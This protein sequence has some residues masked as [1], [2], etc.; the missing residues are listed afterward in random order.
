MEKTDVNKLVPYK[1]NARAHSPKQVEQIARSIKAFGF[2]NP[3]LVDEG[4]VVIAGHGRLAA[5]KRLGLKE[6]PVVRLNHLSEKEKKAYILADNR[7]AEKASWDPARLA[8]EIKE[9]SVD[10][11]FDLSLT[12]FET[13]ETDLILYGQSAPDEAETWDEP[14][15]IPRLVQKG[16][17]WALGRHKLVCGDALDADTLA[18]LMGS[19]K[20]D[21][22]LTDPPYNVKIAGHVCGNGKIKHPEFAMASGE[23]KETEF[24][25]FLTRAFQNLRAFSKDG[26]LHF[27][28]IDWR[29][30]RVMLEAGESVYDEL[31]NIC[32]WAKD[33]GAMGSL[34]RS[35]HELVCVF[36]NGGAPHCNNIE[37]GKYGRCRTNVW[38]YPGVR[39]QSRLSKGEPRLHP[40]V[41]PAGLLADVL[42]D[43]S[44]PGEIALDVFGGSGSTLLAAE[45][46]GRRAR[47]AELDPHYCDVILYRYEK[48]GGK[49]VKLVRRAKYEIKNTQ[50]PAGKIPVRF[51]IPAAG[52]KKCVMR[53]RIRAASG[54]EPLSA[55]TV[56]Q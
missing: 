4:N 17:V 46:T 11:D 38:E 14:V 6:V 42:L 49:D 8:V 31:K 35:R 33:A 2:N 50:T 55:R 18:L 39:V 47:L 51:K 20:A 15:Q 28:F 56:R 22:V 45:R 9:L 32:V 1:G 7:L 19:E 43:C 25:A 5:A 48:A 16:D 54:A 27:A 24:K 3:I 40:T 44:R 53:R 26:S 21:I 12:G 29:H 41:K 34:Y 30:A 23:M 10:A 36:K 37:L 52:R 13:P